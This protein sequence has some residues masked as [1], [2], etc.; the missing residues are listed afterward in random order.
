M[1]DGHLTKREE[2]DMGGESTNVDSRRVQTLREDV[3]N[4]FGHD[5]AFWWES[6]NGHN[7][8]EKDKWTFLEHNGV[9][10]PDIFVPSK[11]SVKY[12]GKDVGLNPYQEEVAIYWTQTLGTEWETKKYY[13]DNFVKLFI[14]SFESSEL[15]QQNPNLSFDLFDFSDIKK[16]LERQ[17]QVR[18]DMSKD[19]KNK[20]KDAKSKLEEKYKYAIIDGALEKLS[21]FRIE[22]PGLFRGRGDHPKAGTLKQR[23]MP[24]DIQLNCSKDALV[25]ICPLPGRCW[26]TVVSQKESGWLASYLEACTNNRK[27]IFLSAGSKLK[28]QKDMQKYERA[29]RLK[30]EIDRI[31]KDYKEK[32]RSVDTRDRQLGTAAYLIDNLAIRV[33]NEKK[34]DEADTV[35]CCSLR[36]EHINFEENYEITL[37]FLGKDSMRYLNTVK[38]DEQA[39]A[40][41][42]LFCAKKEP[43]DDIFDLIN[44]SRLNEY[45]TSLM[46][47]LTAKVF[48]TYNASMTLQRELDKILESIKSTDTLEKKLDAYTEAN[49][50]VAILCNHQKGVSK[51]FDET[52]AKQ[53]EKIDELRKEYKKLKKDKQH[54][55]ADKVQDRIEKAEK[56][57]DKR[58]KNK[59]VALGTSK[60]N[61]NDPRISVAWCKAVEVPIEKVFTSVLLEKFVWAMNTDSTWKF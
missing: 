27:Y 23:T 12:N 46:P 34:E 53:Q 20:L 54:A 7:E 10:F 40:N 14:E 35:G 6:N 25:S 50:R 2:M 19:D 8:D 55:K 28:G 47:E 52:T 43:S 44:S 49:R 29:R 42:K 57:M 17:K 4:K 59:S 51:N 26:G 58:I 33:G 31:R 18:D 41:L 60:I 32:M 3:S 21:N 1:E 16:V 24:E 36:K 45:L 39:Y 30:G 11:L 15:I 22:P 13:R 56:N 9:I 61:Y 38:V 5:G 48:R 37:D